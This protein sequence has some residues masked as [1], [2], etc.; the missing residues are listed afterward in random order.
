MKIFI[1]GNGEMTGIGTISVA[2]GVKGL[3]G[4]GTGTGSNNGSG[5]S[6]GLAGSTFQIQISQL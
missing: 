1:I 4:L 5:G 6:D 3:K 2:G